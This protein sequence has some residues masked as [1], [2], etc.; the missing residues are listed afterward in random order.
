DDGDVRGHKLDE[1]TGTDDGGLRQTLFAAQA[2]H[3]AFDEAG[4]AE[5]EPRLHGVDGIA[6]EHVGGRFER[7]AVELG[8]AAGQRAGGKFE[9]GGDDDAKQGAAGGDNVEGG[10]GAHVYGDAGPRVEMVGGDGVDDA[11]G[12]DFGGVV[13]GDA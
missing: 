3:E 12:A 8:G 10:G 2:L 6:T 1:A 13:G 4:I 7:H 11:V 9:A 5:D